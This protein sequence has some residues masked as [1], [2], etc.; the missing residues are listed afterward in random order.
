MSEGQAEASMFEDQTEGAWIS[1]YGTLA[2]G[3][4]VFIA[5]RGGGDEFKIEFARNVTHQ[6]C[7]EIARDRSYGAFKWVPRQIASFAQVEG[8]RCFAEGDPCK[9][10]CKGLGCMCHPTLRICVSKSVGGA[11]SEKLSPASVSHARSE[12]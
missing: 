11:A 9:L 6:R 12:S 10:T 3:T 7:A 4:G 2:N 8:A 5:I 1:A